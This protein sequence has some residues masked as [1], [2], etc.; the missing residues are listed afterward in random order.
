MEVDS[1]TAIE[2]IFVVALAVIALAFGIKKVLKDWRISE[3]GDSVMQLMHKELERMS[4]QNT[5]LSTEL[6]KLQQEII[7]LNAQ[8]RQ[9]CIENDKLQTEVIALTN[10]LNAFKRVAAVRKVK[11]SSNATS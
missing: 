1:N 6:N 3:A 10:E 7:Q 9:L 4:A 11:V 5:V 2:T 8:L